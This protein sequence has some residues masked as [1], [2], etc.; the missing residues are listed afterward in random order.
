MH[1][2]GSLLFRV[3]CLP[4]LIC[5]SSRLPHLLDP[6]K[7][8]MYLTG[9]VFSTPLPV[10]MDLCLLP[11]SSNEPS[12]WRNEGRPAVKL[13]EKGTLIVASGPSRCYLQRDIKLCIDS[14]LVKSF[15]R[16]GRS[17]KVLCDIVV[18]DNDS[19][20]RT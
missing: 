15:S 9:D 5:P 7:L 16:M 10:C 12:A 3:C 1:I 20:Q 14:R 8:S 19:S 18:G 11:D 13:S 17:E 4:G 6:N 2:Q